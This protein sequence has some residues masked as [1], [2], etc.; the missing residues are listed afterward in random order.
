M[1]IKVIVVLVTL[2]LAGC[3]GAAHMQD[4]WGDATRS[5]REAS[6]VNQNGQAV[7]VSALD[8]MKS[9]QVVDAYRSESGEMSSER[10]VTDVGSG[11]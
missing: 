2:I 11:G 9:N 8:G 4:G 1:Y 10:I 5:Y 7:T 6:V 3:T